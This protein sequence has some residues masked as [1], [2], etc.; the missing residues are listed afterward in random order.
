MKVAALPRD[1]NPYQELLH[2]ELRRQGVDVSYLDGP[3]GSQ[4]LNL[5]VRPVQLVWRRLRGTQVLHIHWVYDFVPTWATSSAWG[6]RVAQAW[7]NGCLWVAHRAR[8]R[9]VWTAHNVL[10]HEQVFADDLAARRSL[11]RT[12]SV[13]LVHSHAT[14]SAVREFGARSVAVGP[15]GSY[16]DRYRDPPSR[17]AARARLGLPSDSLVIA[18]V[19]ALRPYKGTHRLLAQAGSR[20]AGPWYLVAGACPDPGYRERLEEL[21]RTAGPQVRLRIGWMSESELGDHLAAAD[22]AVFP[23]TA[24]ANSGS[25]LL[26]LGAGLPIVVPAI[27]EFAE[28]PDGAT[29]RFVN[30]D[31]GLAEALDRADRLSSGQLEEMTDCAARFAGQQTWHAVATAA[32]AAYEV[33]VDERWAPW[34]S[35]TA[36]ETVP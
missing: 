11:A 29:M 19:G 5:L 28:L 9:V 34:P 12:A 17:E 8:L 24:V 7:F 36:A 35:M 21:A 25:V 33:A 30:T 1:A 16:T 23:F 3:T 18:H 27:P 6:R 4:T 26:A 15:Q 20:P 13:V 2:A 32:R 10:P 31:A 22:I 14:A